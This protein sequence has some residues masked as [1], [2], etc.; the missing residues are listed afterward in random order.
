MSDP[1]AGAEDQLSDLLRDPDPSRD[2]RLQATGLREGK[3]TKSYI[4]KIVR[5]ELEKLI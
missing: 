1:W 5:E 2:S 4:E 3:V